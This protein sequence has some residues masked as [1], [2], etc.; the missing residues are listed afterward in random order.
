MAKDVEAAYG[1]I[2]A[3]LAASKG[4]MSQGQKQIALRVAVALFLI[5]SVTLVAVA[6]AIANVH[7]G[8]ELVSCPCLAESGEPLP[9]EAAQEGA[10]AEGASQEGGSNV[11]S[12]SSEIFQLHVPLGTCT[13]E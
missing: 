10:A 13:W 2:P 5:G 9:A 6:V 7:M 8:I 1:A 3:P 11:S 4:D 12:S